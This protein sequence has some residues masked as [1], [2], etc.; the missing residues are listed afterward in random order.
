[1]EAQLDTAFIRKEMV[2]HNQ[3]PTYIYRVIQGTELFTP[4]EPIARKQS[5]HLHFREQFDII[6][7]FSETAQISIQD[8]YYQQPNTMHSTA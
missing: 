8:V 1:M 4:C 2:H 3:A 6:N 5:Y 7:F